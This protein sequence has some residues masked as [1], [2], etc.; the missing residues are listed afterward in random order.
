MWHCLVQ[1]RLFRR[2]LAAINDHLDIDI[3]KHVQ[4][5]KD[6]VLKLPEKGAYK[7]NMLVRSQF[8]HRRGEYKFKYALRSNSSITF[9][10]KYDSNST[11]FA[12]SDLKFT[13][14]ADWTGDV[15]TNRILI[16]IEITLYRTI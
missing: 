11:G 4:F 13:K 16:I 8:Q 6:P 15:I 1:K 7:T 9:K 5:K 2:L 14:L 12:I 3:Y 10:I